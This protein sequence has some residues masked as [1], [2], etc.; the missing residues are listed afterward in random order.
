M[1]WSPNDSKTWRG[2]HLAVC[3]LSGLLWSHPAASQELTPR[4]YWPTPNGTQVGVIG[5]VFATG[6]VYYDPSVPLYGVNS[7]VNIVQ[8][9][10]LRTFSVWGRTANAIVELPYESSTSNGLIGDIPAE[11]DAFGFGDLGVTFAINLL[12]APTMTPAEF[13]ALRQDPHPILGAS[14]KLIAP[15][16]QYNSD[17]L[18]NVGGNRWALKAELGTVIPLRPKWLLELEA[19]VW[20]LGDDDEFVVGERKQEPII[21]LEL[22]MVK[23]FKPGFWASLDINY[24]AGG[25]QTIGG[26]E[27]AD[28]QRNS[29]IGGTVV[30]P[31]KGRHA[32]KVGYATGLFTEFGT[33]FD[34]Y[35]VSYQVLLNRIGKPR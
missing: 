8:L 16:G 1:R 31:F 14:L 7:D 23:R 11:G 35:L 30:V 2:I 34:Q 21:G 24:F 10:Y 29:R 6:N 4:F 17:K 9:G 5:Y 32:I 27:L 25:R 33:D 3:V 13:Q 19:G 28:D 26:N 22:H 15:I 20:F 12:G 18:L